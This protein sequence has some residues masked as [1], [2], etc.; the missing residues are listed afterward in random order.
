MYDSFFYFG[1]NGKHFVMV[2]EV[3][4]RNFLSLIKAYDYKGMPM[5]LVREIA[6]QSLI[7]LDYMHRFCG[8]IHTDIKPENIV[9][10]LTDKEKQ[11]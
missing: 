5:P 11:D 4:G 3:L 8:V 9:F 7:G 2:F 10:S 1:P 6:R